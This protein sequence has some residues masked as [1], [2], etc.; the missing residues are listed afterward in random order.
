MPSISAT[1]STRIRAGKMTQVCG[2]LTIHATCL[3]HTPTDTTWYSKYNHLGFLTKHDTLKFYE[4]KVCDYQVDEDELYG[5]QLGM[6]TA[7]N[8]DVML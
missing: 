4:C 7:H 8:A 5:T 6:T 2:G 3:S 1:Y